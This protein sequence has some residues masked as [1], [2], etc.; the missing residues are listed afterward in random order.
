MPIQLALQPG[1]YDKVKTY[2][3]AETD[4]E[5][6][7]RLEISIGTVNKAKLASKNKNLPAPMYFVVAASRATAWPLDSFAQTTK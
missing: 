1:I 7:K 5:V 4:Q 3:N 2:L 6:A